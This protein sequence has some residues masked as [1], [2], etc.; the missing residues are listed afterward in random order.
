MWRGKLVPGS[1]AIA[2][3]AI[4]AFVLTYGWPPL[5]AHSSMSAAPQ[6][7]FPMNV[8]DR[9]HKG[10]RLVIDPLMAGRQMFDTGVVDIHRPDQSLPRGVPRSSNLQ[11]A[12]PEG[13]DP[14]FGPLLTAEQG[15]FA[16]RCVS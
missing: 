2:G 10:D 15:N 5:P 16:G 14:V 13:C 3:A 7:A 1:L 4:T 12:I 11:P 6:T 8:V 9:S